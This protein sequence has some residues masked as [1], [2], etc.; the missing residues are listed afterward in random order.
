MPSLTACGREASIQHFS[1]TFS[2]VLTSSTAGIKRAKEAPMVFKALF[3][4]RIANHCTQPHH[5]RVYDAT[6]GRLQE[7]CP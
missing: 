3:M 4:G 1:S 6:P 2:Q 5:Q 7:D